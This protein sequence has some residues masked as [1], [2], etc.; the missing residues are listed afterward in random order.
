GDRLMQRLSLEDQVNSA[1]AQHGRAAGHRALA[2]GRAAMRAGGQLALAA[3]PQPRASSVDP[4]AAPSLSAHRIGSGSRPGAAAG[5]PSGPKN[6][7]GA[8]R[9]SGSSHSARPPQPGSAAG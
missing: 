3:P 1:T 8:P 4:S 6:V 5:P 2:D 9:R 7:P